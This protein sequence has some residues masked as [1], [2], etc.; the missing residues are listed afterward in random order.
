MCIAIATI[1]ETL[2]S[3]CYIHKQLMSH[4]PS[5]LLTTAYVSPCTRIGW[6]WRFLRSLKVHTQ[7]NMFEYRLPGEINEKKSV[8]SPGKATI[9]F[10]GCWLFKSRHYTFFC[11]DIK[12]AMALSMRC[13]KCHLHIAES[14]AAYVI[15]TTYSQK[16]HPCH[17]RSACQTIAICF[18]ANICHLP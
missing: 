10:V 17:R 2:Q 6:Q 18:Y 9:Q 14:S 7:F 5:L 8:R 16:C 4:L 15:L 12:A 3:E 13:V 11:L 1:K